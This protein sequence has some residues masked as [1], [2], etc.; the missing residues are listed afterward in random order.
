MTRPEDV[1]R[2]ARA[3]PPPVWGRA[4]LARCE[5]ILETAFHRSV[6]SETRRDDL[7]RRL[8]SAWSSSNRR[9]FERYVV[10]IYAIERKMHRERQK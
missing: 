10:E 5:S 9:A 7:S 4:T 8:G 2:V 3:T 6:I 1:W